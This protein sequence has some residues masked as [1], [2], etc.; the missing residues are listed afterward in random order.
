VNHRKV[1][2]ISP[3]AVSRENKRGQGVPGDWRDPK[4]V[5]KSSI[6][7]ATDRQRTGELKCARLCFVRA[8]S[9]ASEITATE[10]SN[11][12]RYRQT[13][14]CWKTAA[15]GISFHD[16]LQ[17]FLLG[18][19]PVDRSSE[20]MIKIIRGEGSKQ[21]RAVLQSQDD[22]GHSEPRCPSFGWDRVSVPPSSCCV[23]DSV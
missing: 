6:D 5:C 9:S 20:I 18:P 13:A 11:C 10:L 16:V 23:L 7:K 19:D 21:G 17:L 1:L 15:E 12:L 8:S 22:F 2:K 3:G 14:C 4:P